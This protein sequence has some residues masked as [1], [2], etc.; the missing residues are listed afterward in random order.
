M[1]YADSS[2]VL[3]ILLDQPGPRMPLDDDER[4][5]PR[6]PGG[7]TCAASDLPFYSA[8]MNG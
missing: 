4:L 7:W 3:R 1:K 6:A 8:S 5:V 2:A